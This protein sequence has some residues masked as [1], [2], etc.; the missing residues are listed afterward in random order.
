[1][2]KAEAQADSPKGDKE[3]VLKRINELSKENISE[4]VRVAGWLQFKRMAGQFL[5]LRDS[6]GSVQVVISDPLVGTSNYQMI[7]ASHF[8]TNNFD[9]QYLKFA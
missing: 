2:H 6:Y 8:Q 3:K 5:V 4:K 9:E 1:M 7:V